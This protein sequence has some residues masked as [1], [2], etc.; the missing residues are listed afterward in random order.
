M[1]NLTERAH[2]TAVEKRETQ[3]PTLR[4]QIQQ[5]ESQ[6]ALAMPKGMEAAQLVRDAL[7]ALKQTPKLAECTPQ[8]VLGSLMTCAQLGLRPGVLGHAW[9]LPYWD[10]KSKSNQAQLIV[11][12]KGYVELGYRSGHIA[13]IIGRTVYEGDTFDVEYGLDDKLVHKPAMKGPRSTPVAHYAMV[14]L[15]NGG[16]SFW[17]MTEDEMQA[18]KDRYAPRNRAGNIVGPWVSDYEAMARK[19]CLLRL[20]SWLPKST[21]MAYAVEVDNGVRTNVD[22]SAS[23]TEVT[24]HY[25]QV[26]D[27]AGETGQGATV[28]PNVCPECQQ[29]KHQNCEGQAWDPEADEPGPCACPD[30][31]HGAQS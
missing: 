31:A 17:V 10:S 24:H 5:M 29:G 6:F 9:V 4:D 20:A 22:P 7:T 15:A 2:G 25:E 23:L 28:V 21:E 13:S 18:W 27:P 26:A 14:K 12:Y 3:G 16:R 30:E 8:S 11:G 19:T 1:S